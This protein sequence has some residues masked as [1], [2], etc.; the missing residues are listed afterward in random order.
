VLERSGLLESRPAASL[1]PRLDAL[2]RG[3]DNLRRKLGAAAA[4]L[5]LVDATRVVVRSMT[6]ADDAPAGTPTTDALARHLI[7][8][9]DS[10]T[11]TLEEL[12]CVEAPVTVAGQILGWVVAADAA[13]RTFS[14]DDQRAV[15]D[16]ATAVSSEVRLRVADYETSR[17]RDLVAAHNTLHALIAKG[18]PLPEVLT[19]LVESVERY[20]P[21]VIPCVVLLDRESST[22]KPGAGPSLPPHYLAMIDGVVIGPNVGTCGSAAWSGEMVIS[23]NIAGDPKWAP[24][25]D[26]A[27]DAGLAH[28]WS[29]PITGADGDVLGTFALY[30]ARPRH[31]EPEH[32]E[33]MQ[34]SARLAGIAIERDR[35]MQRLIHD[36]RSDGLTGLPNR[37]AIFERLDEALETVRA[38]SRI[39]VLFVDLDGLKALNDTLGHDRAD[40]VIRLVGERLRKAVRTDD[41]VGRFGGDEF[42]VIADDVDARDQA[43]D[44]ATRVLE[45]ISEPLSILTATVVTASVGIAVIDRSEVDAREAIRLADG[46]MYAAKHAGRDGL[47]FSDGAPELRNER[48]LQLAR[49]LRN[50]EIRGE[51]SLVFQPVFNLAS[52]RIVGVE[53]LARWD[54]PELGSVAPEE[55]IPVAEETGSIIALGAWALRES[56]ETLSTLDRQTGT[57][58]E[59]AVNVSAHQLSVPGFAQSVAKTLSHAEFPAARL[60]IEISESA[61]AAPD[62][63]AVRALQE[64]QALGIG[65]VVDDFGTGYSSL[66][67]LKHHPVRGI[68][69]AR[70]L[71]AGLPDDQ[72]DAAVITGVL[73]TAAS[74]GATVTAKGVETPTQLD[75]LDALHCER[76]QGFLLAEPVAAESLA[77]LL[78]H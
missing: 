37:R 15:A 59:L 44:L 46:A 16:L 35:T 24:I 48:R 11:A 7:G 54:S 72:I 52:G 2:E 63:A 36:A 69:I 70:D 32:I 10:S 64:L 47:C 6:T 19:E 9:V 40:E 5:L 17:V 61:L 50:A 78:D 27:L 29:M 20:E 62:P 51:M 58:L 73:A 8:R 74:L 26:I 71:V 65:I 23:D 31:P 34:D 67:W 14:A 12:A 76:I 28:C 30:G 75:A 3:L 56:C 4:A 77:A 66:T 68:K 39:A 21:S 42:I 49:D 18:A 33:L 38:D 53:A 43:H 25:R 60:T 41:F 57:G 45:A 22:L 1:Q 55:F 13:S